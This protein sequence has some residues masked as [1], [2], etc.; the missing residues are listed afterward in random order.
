MIVNVIA[1]RRDGFDVD[2]E[3]ETFGAP[4]GTEQE[5]IGRVRDACSDYVTMRIREGEQDNFT[6]MNESSY[7]WF[8]LMNEEMYD[9]VLAEH[10]LAMG[11]TR[12]TVTPESKVMTI[13]VNA[14]EVIGEYLGGDDD[15][16]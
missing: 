9:S 2:T 5:F 4:D 13:F 11:L 15:G 14:D 3:L 8:D 12:L 16:E 1:T 10:D 7:N 6:C